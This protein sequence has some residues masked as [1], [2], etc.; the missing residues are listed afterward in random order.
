MTTTD[1]DERDFDERDFDE[2]DFDGRDFDA[3]DFDETDFDETDFI[4][5]ANRDWFALATSFGLFDVDREFLPATGRRDVGP[6]GR[7][8]CRTAH[9][10]R[11][12]SRR[13]S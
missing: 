5:R 8:R 1:S 12:A 10:R 11:A 13:R 6:S 7:V 3:P 4:A 2:R 9:P